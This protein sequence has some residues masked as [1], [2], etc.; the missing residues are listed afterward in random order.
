MRIEGGPSSQIQ[1]I[2]VSSKAGFSRIDIA[3][4]QG[5]MGVITDFAAG[6]V[7][8]LLAPMQ[9]VL[10]HA[11]GQLPPP[12]AAASKPSG[13]T[14][15][16]VKETILGYE[17]EKYVETSPTETAEIWVTDQL[18]TFAGLMSQGGPAQRQAQAWEGALKGH[19]FFPMRVISTPRG[20]PSFKLEVTAVNKEAL[21]DSDFQ[22]PPGWRVQEMGGVGGMP[23]GMP[24]ARP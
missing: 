4:P 1:N 5:Q 18:G 24:G 9:M 11:I 2:T 22:A 23:F 12:S 17:C 19:T 16:G 6:K 20:K 15:T 14:D 13:L 7:L 8:M 21:P 3:T 10:V